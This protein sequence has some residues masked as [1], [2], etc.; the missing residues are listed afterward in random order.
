[1]NKAMI[2]VKPMDTKNKIPYRFASILPVGIAIALETLPSGAVC[3]FAPNPTDRVRQTFSYFDLTPFG[4]ANFGPFLTAIISCLLLAAVGI[5]LFRDGAGIRKL[6]L[7]LSLASVIASLLPLA[8]GIEYF[9]L[10]AAGIALCLALE[11]AALRIQNKQH[12]ER[13]DVPVSD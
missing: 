4:Y 6:S 3:V 1:M 13:R 9:T 7:A 10:T 8:F 12:K 2:W 11:Y 5:G